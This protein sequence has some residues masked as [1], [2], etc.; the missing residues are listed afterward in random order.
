MNQEQAQVLFKE[1]A[2]LLVQGMPEGNEFGIDWKMWT[3]GPKFQ[4]VK[5]IPPGVHFISYCSISKSSGDRSPKTGFFHYFKRHDIVVKKWDEDKEEIVD[6]KLSEEEKIM[7]RANLENIDRNLGPYPYDMFR[8]W[9]S[10]SSEISENLVV[11]LS[12]KNV[13]I[14]SSTLY[15]PSKCDK[16]A[17]FGTTDVN[18][19]P[20]IEKDPDSEI[21]F[22]TIPKHWFP[23]G[24]SSAERS[25][26]SMD[27]SH[28]L[29]TTLSNYQHE[30][31][32][33]GELQYSFVCFIL[34]QVLDAF[35]HWRRLVVIL[36]NCEKGLPTHLDIYKK[37]I[38]VLYHQLGEIS[39][40]FFV[41]IV[42]TNNFLVTHLTTFFSNIS[43]SNNLD[44]IETANK[45]R[46][47]LT[48]RYKWKFNEEPADW[49][50]VVVET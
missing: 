35:D 43:L 49:A 20:V 30:C 37:L 11:K 47:H 6:K 17:K 21:R 1:G 46:K 44:L 45:F 38:A 5:M 25:Q 27:S 4:G 36:C 3:T 19:L 39:P 31:E 18:G 9:V 14:S 41:D 42:S 50:P 26:Y 22:T 24:C 16:T 33:L 12:P 8:K 29:D 13:S 10:M 34:G 40:D 15:L 7:L 23:D 2:L 28:A 32:I 48:K